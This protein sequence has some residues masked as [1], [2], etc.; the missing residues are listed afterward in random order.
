MSAEGLILARLRS[1]KL[2]F[3]TT[4]DGE[5]DIQVP[6]FAAEYRGVCGKAR[7]H[8]ANSEGDRPDREK[9][10]NAERTCWDM[11]DFAYFV[12]EI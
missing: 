2:T 5:T 9:L 10:Y 8:R 11:D 7:A 12:I 1:P 3:L 6:A 4:R